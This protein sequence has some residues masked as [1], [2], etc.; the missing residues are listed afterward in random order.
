[1]A[2]LFGWLPA[3]H[4]SLV[5]FLGE[6]IG[7]H[8]LRTSCLFFRVWTGCVV[9]WCPEQQGYGG[10]CVCKKNKHTNS[11]KYFEH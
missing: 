7:F 3:L 6:V 5:S 2:P 9:L 1:M 4:L 8:V 10:V 11:G